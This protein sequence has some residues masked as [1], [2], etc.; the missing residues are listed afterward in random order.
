LWLTPLISP[1]RG[2]GLVS[3]TILWNPGFRFKNSSLAVS[4]PTPL[5]PVM[6]SKMPLHLEQFL[7]EDKICRILE[8][9]IIKKTTPPPALRGDEI[10][11]NC[12]GCRFQYCFILP[13]FEKR[14]NSLRQIVK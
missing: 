5:G 10:G 1:S 6:T 4:F 3:E 12:Q 13:F 2:K 9:I 7:A 8:N 14:V 11:Q